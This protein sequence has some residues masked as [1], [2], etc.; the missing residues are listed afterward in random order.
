MARTKKSS[1]RVKNTA[2]LCCLFGVMLIVGTYA[3]FIGMQSVVVSQ[4][5]VKIAAAEGL[6]LSMDGNVWYTDELDAKE[7]AAYTGNTN[8][9]AEKGLIPMSS[10]GDTNED[11]SEMILFEKGS[12]TA[13]KGGYRLL[14]STVTYTGTSADELKD[15]KG[16]V[17]FDL[18]IKNISGEEY[19]ADNDVLNE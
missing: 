15:G 18:F 8:T 3:W 17:A 10:V 4:F 9:W 6:E 11:A 12:L 7:T 2:I 16:Y 5:D 1:N 14:A 19:Y 13:T